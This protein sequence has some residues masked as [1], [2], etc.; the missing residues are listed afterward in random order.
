MRDCNTLLEE[1]FVWNDGNIFRRQQKPE[2][3]EGDSSEKKT[4]E[5]PG[6]QQGPGL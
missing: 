4:S 6:P 2:H 3:T 1:G 5:P